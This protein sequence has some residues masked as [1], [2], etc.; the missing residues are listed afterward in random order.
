VRKEL[1]LFLQYLSKEKRVS[2]HTVKA[3]GSDLEQFIEFIVQTH[4]NHNVPPASCITENHIRAFMG[5][6]MQHGI[7]KRSAA[8]KLASIKALFAYLNKAGWI[9]GNPAVAL[10]SP[11]IE[12]RL[13]QF[14]T[15]TEMTRALDS[16]KPDSNLGLRDR[17]ILELFYGTGMR[18]SELVGLNLVDV[19]W[20]GM[21]IRVFGKGRKMRLLPLGKSATGSLK[22]YM[23]RRDHFHPSSGES[24]VFLNFAGKRIS[25]R[26]V[27]IIVK[28]WLEK[29]SEKKNLSPHLLRHTFAT[30]L[31]DRG[32]D[33]ESVKEL[34][35]HASLST[36][37]MYTH[38][39]TDHLLQVYRQAHPRSESDL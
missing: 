24:A 3:Y 28:R 34:L 13:P 37:Q 2:S 23:S 11:K 1:E 16:I 31:L 21:S 18:L 32:A 33:M 20:E 12:K 22:Q 9:D 30:H 26:G 14:L 5:D 10:V 8:R 6:L 15:E 36:T 38:L 4:R 7:K 25:V 35:G 27:Q 29:A 39:T 19:Q 17:A